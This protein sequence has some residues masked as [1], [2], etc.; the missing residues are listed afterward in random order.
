MSRLA[1]LELQLSPDERA[2]LDNVAG[3]SVRDI[4]RGLVDAVDPDA[5]ARVSASAA[6]PAAAIQGLLDAAVR[7]IAANPQLRQRILEL[8][9]AHDRVIDEVSVDVLQDA[10]GV[11]D[12]SRARAIVEDWRIYLA[13]HRDEIIAI[14]LL[15]EARERRISFTDIKELADRIRRPPHNWTIDLIWAAYEAIE[16]DLVRHS[17]RHT[18]TDLVSLIR[19]T[20]GQDD[21]LVPY[22]DQVRDRYTG[23]LL[24]QQQAGAQFQEK[25]RWWLDRMAEVIAASAGIGPDDLDK[26][27]FIE[28]GGIDGAVRDLGPHAATVM[29]ELNAEL[30]A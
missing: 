30:T 17:D 8:R 7:P 9:R 18:L 19:F 24:Q 16:V 22:A 20:I 1:A 26:A 11:V 3:G 5:Q 27:P 25:E 14:Q 23:W 21:R 2:E 12:T 13:E 29:D 28:R 6:D 10:Y 4:V 15:T